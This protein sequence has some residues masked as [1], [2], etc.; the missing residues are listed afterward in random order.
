MVLLNCSHIVWQLR[1]W[2]PASARL[3]Q[4]R[5]TSLKDLQRIMSARGVRHGSLDQSLTALDETI[6]QLA[7]ESSTEANTLAGI[8]WRLRCSLAQ[9]KQAVPD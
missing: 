3:A 7:A 8:L 2:Q 1:D 4:A 5:E 9:L 6:R